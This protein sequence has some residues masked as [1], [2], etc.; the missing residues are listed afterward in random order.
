MPN[1]PA[2]MHSVDASMHTRP[3]HGLSKA[4]VENHWSDLD[5]Q[6]RPRCAREIHVFLGGGP[7]APEVTFENYSDFKVAH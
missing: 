4:S 5:S 1:R 7:R 2:T 6:G 3:L